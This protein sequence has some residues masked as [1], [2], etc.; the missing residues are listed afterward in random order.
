M[1]KTLQCKHIGPDADC[2]FV[3]RGETNE[4]ILA[5]VAEH[6]KTVHGLSEVP[7]ELVQAALSNIQDES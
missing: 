6:A 4:Q 2:Q 5:Q 1:G 7:P 3:A